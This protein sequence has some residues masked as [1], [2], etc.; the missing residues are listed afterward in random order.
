M[1]ILFVCDYFPPFTPGGAEW[2]SYYLAAALGQNKN[3]QLTVITPNYGNLPFKQEKE[4]FKLIRFPFIFKLKPGQQKLGYF[5]QNNFVYYLYSFFWIF[6]TCLKER[7]DIIHLQSSFSLASLGLLKKIFRKPLVFTFRDTFL[8]CPTGVCLQNK[9]IFKTYSTFSHF[10][11]QCRSSYIKYYLKPQNY[12]KSVYAQFSLF[13]L[14]LDLI[15][16]RQALKRIDKYIFISSALKELY[17]KSNL[18]VAKKAKVVYNLPPLKVRL[19]NKNQIQQLRK[20][21]NLEKRKI[22]LFAGRLT[23]GK[24]VYDLIQAAKLV[25]KKNKQV[26]FLFVGKGKIEGVRAP[27]M[28]II[29]SVSHQKLF[30]FYKLADLVVVPSRGFE[31]FGRI[32]QEAALFSKAVI[33]TQSGGLI[34]QV[35]NK[36]TGLIVPRNNPLKLAEEILKLIK[37][38]DLRSKMGCQGFKYIKHKFNPKKNINNLLLNYQSLQ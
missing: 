28:K 8:F 9:R 23:L 25:Y 16:K 20:K 6:I 11:H 18:V 14:W 24:G 1:R 31:P 7:I 15:V 29:S 36:K 4:G 5:L 27:N 37:N 12:F 35:I 30:K 19:I 33:V 38:K 2:S 10:W 3:I 21:L 17:L 26:I 22:V 13:Y 32:P 34:E